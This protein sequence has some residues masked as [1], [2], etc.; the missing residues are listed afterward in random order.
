MQRY[1][2]TYAEALA[3]ANS[4]ARQIGVEVA[5]RQLDDGRYYL[6]QRHEF[7][8]EGKLIAVAKPE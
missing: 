3:A 4:R 1:H 6:Q 2:Q 5:I 8:T 7:C